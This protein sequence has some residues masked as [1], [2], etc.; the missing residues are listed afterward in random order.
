MLIHKSSVFS[1]GR[2][3]TGLP[4]PSFRVDKYVESIRMKNEGLREV[5]VRFNAENPTSKKTGTQIRQK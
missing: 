3:S 4:A 2:D 5:T 1:S